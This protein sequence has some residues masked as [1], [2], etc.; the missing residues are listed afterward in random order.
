MGISLRPRLY[1]PHSELPDLCRSNGGHPQREVQIWAC[2]FL[3]GG[4]LVLP[5]R[6]ATDLGVFDLRHFDLLKQGCANSGGL[7]LADKYHCSREP[8]L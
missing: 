8:M 5:R 6:E 3:N 4:G 2:L 7:E 1:Q